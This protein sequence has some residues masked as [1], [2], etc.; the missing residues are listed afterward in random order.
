MRRGAADRVAMP[1]KAVL[2]TRWMEVFFGSSRTGPSAREASRRA[3]YV[4]WTEFA[5]FA[6]CE[7]TVTAGAVARMCSPRR[8]FRDLVTSEERPTRR[9]HAA[10]R[11]TL[12]RAM[13]MRE[14]R[15]RILSGP[16]ISVR[17]VPDAPEQLR[18]G[19]AGK[20]RRDAYRREALTE[21][22]HQ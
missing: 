15:A 3:R 10:V 16:R 1:A 7:A 21:G 13:Y 8:V 20:E 9:K 12:R 5:D 19:G 2:L 14:P 18:A 11:D 4:A 22:A 6:K 17:T